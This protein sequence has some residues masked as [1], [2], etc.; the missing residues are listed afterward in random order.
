MNTPEL[1]ILILGFWV[2]VLQSKIKHLEKIV[3]GLLD[4]ENQT[5][6]KPTLETEKPVKVEVKK[7]KNPVY[8]DTLATLKAEHTTPKVTTRVLHP[9]DEYVHTE[10]SRLIQMLRNYF[11]GGNSYLTTPTKNYPIIF[12]RVR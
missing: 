6:V 1:W 4:G 9:K 7:E 12:M 5:T 11:T 2:F 8:V 3:E 10:P